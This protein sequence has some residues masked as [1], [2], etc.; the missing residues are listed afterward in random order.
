[1]NIFKEQDRNI[2]NMI[3][4][5]LLTWSLSFWMRIINPAIILVDVLNA[6][7]EIV[8]ITELCGQ[9]IILL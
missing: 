7:G 9:F 5:V 6:D 4:L 3:V 1:M 2:W 8:V